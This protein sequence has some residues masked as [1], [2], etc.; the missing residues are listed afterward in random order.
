MRTIE[1]KGRASSV[2]GI[3]QPDGASGLVLDPGQPFHINLVNSIGED[4]IIH[5]HGQKP[6]VSGGTASPI[7]M[8]R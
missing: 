7:G 4:T 8:F 5:W 1:V 6:P 2:Y 3:R